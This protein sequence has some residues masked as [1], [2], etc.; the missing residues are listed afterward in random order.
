[1]AYLKLNEVREAMRDANVHPKLRKVLEGLVEQD[2]VRRKQIFDVAEALG[3]AANSIN[4][5]LQMAGKTQE[6]L[7]A[8]GMGK[9]LDSGNV[10]KSMEAQDDEH[11][12]S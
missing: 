4:M 2:A 9:L 1:M 5:L 7:E 6:Q 10:V 11:A 3:Q 12:S 8:M